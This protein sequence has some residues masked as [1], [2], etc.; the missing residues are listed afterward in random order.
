VTVRAHELGHL[1]GMYDEYPQ[2][3][4][5]LVAHGSKLLK[6]RRVEDRTSI[7][8]S[9][10]KV[11]ARHLKEFQQWFESQASSVTGKTELVRL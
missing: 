9:G 1:I 6:D 8:N 11:Y 4:V 10:S 3:A 7:M 2:G 5:N